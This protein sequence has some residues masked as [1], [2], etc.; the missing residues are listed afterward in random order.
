MLITTPFLISSRDQKHYCHGS[1]SCACLSLYT[2]NTILHMKLSTS[3]V[4]EGYLRRK[5]CRIMVKTRTLPSTQAGGIS[6][7]AGPK[8]NNLKYQDMLRLKPFLLEFL[9]F[10]DTNDSSLLTIRT[11]VYPFCSLSPRHIIQLI[12]TIFCLT[13][14]IILP[15]CDHQEG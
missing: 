4:G 5:K 13:M 6:A 8:R 12:K 14:T 7:E 11:Q 1:L 10:D 9:V 2:E 15:N 3:V